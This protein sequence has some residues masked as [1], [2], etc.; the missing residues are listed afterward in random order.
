MFICRGFS[1]CSL[2]LLENIKWWRK[3]VELMN[4]QIQT[5]NTNWYWDALFCL[6]Y[7]NSSFLHTLINFFFNV[8][9]NN[10]TL[11]N[12]TSMHE[13]YNGASIPCA[14][15]S[16]NCTWRIYLISVRDLTYFVVRANIMFGYNYVKVSIITFCDLTI[17]LWICSICEILCGLS[18]FYNIDVG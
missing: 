9:I 2:N 14:F 1:E 3:S 18:W 15:K 6:V 16:Y 8:N 5:C 11:S 10:L 7:E 4:I 17:A 13:M 12:G